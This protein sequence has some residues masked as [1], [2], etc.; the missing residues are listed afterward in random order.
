MFPTGKPCV[1]LG[2]TERLVQTA[3]PAVVRVIQ[4]ADTEETR[5]SWGYRRLAGWRFG[6]TA[7]WKTC[8]TNGC[9]RELDAALPTI[10]LSLANRHP[11][12]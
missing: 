3:Q 2:L 7:G 5:A 4:P 6:D 10:N 9:Q 1:Q 8:A 11:A 12:A